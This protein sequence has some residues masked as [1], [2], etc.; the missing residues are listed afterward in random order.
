[1][2]LRAWNTGIALCWRFYFAGLSIS[3]E[4]CIFFVSGNSKLRDCL[5]AW[6]GSWQCHKAKNLVPETGGQA[7]RTGEAVLELQ[8]SWDI[9]WYET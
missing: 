6:G 7:T 8:V 1:M 2:L 4:Y 9:E 3:V 5:D